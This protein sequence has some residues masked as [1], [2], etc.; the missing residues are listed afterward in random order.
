MVC[1][2]CKYCDH[3][4]GLS[5]CKIRGDVDLL[6]CSIKTDKEIISKKICYNCIFWLGGGEKG[7]SCS[8]KYY[9]SESNGF[10]EAC[11]L[12]CQKNKIAK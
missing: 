1:S 7:L 4:N 10:S 11:D 2:K 5:V 3:I 8:R 6:G 9:M 12:F